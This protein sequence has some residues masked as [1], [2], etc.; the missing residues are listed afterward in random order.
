MDTLNTPE[1]SVTLAMTPALASELQRET[2]ALEVA[3][4]YVIDTP[5]M[6]TLANDELKKRK[7]IITRLKE[8]KAGFVAPAKQIIANAEA[9]FDPAISA[10]QGAEVFLKGAL[11]TWTQEQERIAAE[12]RR[13]DEEEA[14]KARQK[15]EAEAAAARARAEEQARAARAEA[16]AAEKRRLEAE[17]AGNARAAAAAAAEAAKLNAKAESVVEN[18]EAHAQEVVL[19]AAASAEVV[20]PA[21]QKL[22]G[23]S[24]RD[25][26]V[27]ELAPNITN[28]GAILAIVREI[29]AGRNDL[30]P[31][32]QLDMSA[33]GR[34]AKALR[35]S[36]K[37]PGLVAVNRPVAA[38]RK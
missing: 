33:A 26:W 6:A 30:L 14:R 23:F 5:E 37:V 8:L 31:M 35:G 18:A 29:A 3:K 15:A 24:T 20:V 13:L 9:L 10:N 1:L 2:G 11:T 19:T 34:L 27:A 25:N 21:A 7:Q 4:A 32:L 38:S 17:A 16:E 36:F 12:A 28:E 22:A